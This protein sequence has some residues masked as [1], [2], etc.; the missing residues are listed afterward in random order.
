MDKLSFF[1]FFFSYVPDSDSQLEEAKAFDVFLF[2]GGPELHS[3]YCLSLCHSRPEASTLISY[4]KSPTR[5]K[6]QQEIG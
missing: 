1:F 5:P 3:V 2:L 4:Y 6:T